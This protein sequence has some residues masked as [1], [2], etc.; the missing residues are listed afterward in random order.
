MYILVLEEV[1][2]PRPHLLPWM[3]KWKVSP[4]MYKKMKN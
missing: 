4:Y 2:D 1:V 3:G